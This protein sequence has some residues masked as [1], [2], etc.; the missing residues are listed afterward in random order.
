[1]GWRLDDRRAVQHS[2]SDKD[3]LGAETFSIAPLVTYIKDI[4]AWPG[5]GAFFALMN[6]YQFDVWKD[7]ARPEQSMY[8]GRYFVMLP[9]SKKFKIYT[10]PEFQPIYD[11]ENDHFSFWAGP[12]FGKM[13]SG[14]NILYLKPGFG[15]DSEAEA[16]DR[17]WSFEFG[18][19][20]FLN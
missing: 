2:L 5:P 19:R 4:P 20:K 16:G 8:I 14:G 15:V 18:W 12:E 10:L 6:F 7:D 9:L 17:D 11:F 13:M 3:V 1:M